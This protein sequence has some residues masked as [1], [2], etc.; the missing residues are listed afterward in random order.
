MV[1]ICFWT[2]WLCPP[3]IMVLENMCYI[4]AFSNKIILAIM[5]FIRKTTVMVV[6]Q[7]FDRPS[8]HPRDLILLSIEKDFLK[9]FLTLYP[10]PPP[11]CPQ[12]YQ[13]SLVVEL[14]VSKRDLFSSASWVLS[15]L[16]KLGIHGFILRNYHSAS[17]LRTWF[18]FVSP[19]SNPK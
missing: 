4:F 13:G 11:P 7:I 14:I 17:F 12:C 8:M 15:R 1:L 3:T 18:I 10:L 6:F 9:E 5:T 19:N 2:I 16:K